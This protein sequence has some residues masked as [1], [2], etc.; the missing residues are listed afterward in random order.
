V[1]ISVPGAS[2][3]LVLQNSQANAEVFWG[4]YYQVSNKTTYGYLVKAILKDGQYVIEDDTSAEHFYSYLKDSNDIKSTEVKNTAQGSPYPGTYAK[5]IETLEARGKEL[6]EKLSIYTP[7]PTPTITSTI[8]PQ[9]KDAGS[10]PWAVKPTP[11]FTDDNGVRYY[12]TNDDIALAWAFDN[13]GA[14][15]ADGNEWGAFIF[16]KGINGQTAYYTGALIIGSQ[17]SMVTVED[18]NNFWKHFDL[19]QNPVGYIHTHGNQN[20]TNASGL[21]VDLI[22]SGGDRNAAIGISEDTGATAYAYMVNVYGTLRRLSVEP[23]DKITNQTFAD[24][25][26]VAR[27]ARGI[28]GGI[29]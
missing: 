16:Q 10:A 13:F 22:F 15:Y 8:T 12:A 3:N 28:P 24:Q 25:N 20:R 7:K 23:N 29:R 19:S 14:S 21:A 1:Q 27:I 17:R 18:P 9:D 2:V 6:I 4:A 11:V 5:E 26:L